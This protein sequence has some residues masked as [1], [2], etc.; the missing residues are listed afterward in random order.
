MVGGRILAYLKYFQSFLSRSGGYVV[1]FGV[2]VLVVGS[3]GWVTC[4]WVGWLNSDIELFWKLSND[5][6]G[7]R[8]SYGSWVL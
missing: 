1:E 6:C 4:G 7:V 8:K 3:G 2:H 5:S